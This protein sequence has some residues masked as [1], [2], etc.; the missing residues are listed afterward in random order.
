MA[1]PP[2]VTVEWTAPIFTERQQG[3][4]ALR[5]GD[6]APRRVLV[7]GLHGDEFTPHYVLRA[8]ARNFAAKL[9]GTIDVV[10]AVNWLGMLLRRRRY[11]VGSVDLNHSFRACPQRAVATLLGDL[12]TF[13]EGADLVVDLHSW[14]SPTALVGITYKAPQE[15]DEAWELLERFG[16]D[17]VWRPRKP[18]FQGTLGAVLK[19]R[20]TPYCGIELPPQQLVDEAGITSYSQQLYRALSRQVPRTPVPSGGR[21]LIHAGANGLL[22]PC[23]VPGQSV[24]EGDRLAEIWCPCSFEPV[25]ETVCR[26]QGVLLHCAPRGM[27]QAGELVHIVGCPD[28]N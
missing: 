1:P 17:F 16:C 23:A 13:T 27:V 20:D 9:G 18:E 28:P 22:C 10:P 4:Q 6:G 15:A 3:T 7:A 26:R 14:D 24:A 25:S 2:P 19:E 21:E 12:V 5:W 8:F 11:P